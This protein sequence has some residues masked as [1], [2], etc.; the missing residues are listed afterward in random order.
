MKYYRL[1]IGIIAILL[2]ANMFALRQPPRGEPAGNGGQREEST[3]R[4]IIHIKG[5]RMFPIKVGDSTVTSL[6]GKVVAYHNGSVI[7]CDS[8]VRFSDRRVECFG[9][10]IINKDST[11]VYGDR[12][13]YDGDRNLAR[14]YSPLIKMI[15]G[16]AVLYTY[17]FIFNTLDN[18]GEY[19]G[20]GIV[21]RGDTRME[22]DKG[23]Y[24][25]DTKDFVCVD[26]A[27]LEDL[28]YQIMSDSLGYNMDTEVASFHT[29]TY[30]WNDKGEILSANKGWY[31]TAA[32]HYHFV[33]DAYIMTAEQ[34][35]WADDINYWSNVEDAILRNN[36]QIREEEQ[37][38]L[39]F[40]DYGLYFGESG[41]A[42]LTENPSL[43][44]FFEESDTLYMRSDTI[45]L[46]VIDSTSIYHPNY[47][48]DKAAQASAAAVGEELIGG[49]QESVARGGQEGMPGPAKG[50]DSSPEAA[51]PSPEAESS[52]ASPAEDTGLSAEQADGEETVP[53]DESVTDS[54]QEPEQL[55]A[56]ESGGEVA[57]E[58]APP[59]KE[60]LRAQQKAEKEKIK[61][62]KKKEKEARR[63][64]REEERLAKKKEKEA[65]RLAKVGQ[66]ADDVISLE[67]A[68]TA[69]IG[70]DTDASGGSEAGS[71][72]AD[73]A[74]DVETGEP[75]SE[76]D[77]GT[78][79]EGGAVVAD[80]DFAPEQE[81]EDESKD[82]V[83][84]GY[85]NVKIW[86]SDFQAVCDSLI[87]FSIDTTI[88]MHIEPLLWSGENQISSEVAVIYIVNEQLSRAVFSGGK[89]IM[90]SRIDDY[91][92]NQVSGKVI[93]AFFRDNELYRTDAIGNGQTYYFLQNDDTG[94][95]QGFLV[96]ES[97]DITFHI[98]EQTVNTI[99][100]RGNPDV[101]IYPMDKI[102]AGQERILPD[103]EWRGHLR[104][105]KEDVFNRNIRPSQRER[106][107]GMAMP[108]F[109]LTGKILNRK[110]ELIKSGTWRDRD[111]D[112]SQAARDFIRQVEASMGITN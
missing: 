79:E 17:N 106:Y 35:V 81:P 87:A 101:I 69:E 8:A 20:G 42:V 89:P 13:D 10:V 80:G 90:A 21:L 105:E 60:E 6:V 36:I 94:E 77:A 71:E 9:N 82:R 45:F 104:P 46:Y 107:T 67:D 64:A 52:S 58:P 54:G 33:S 43:V 50:A 44:S 37:K 26:D 59:T 75:V 56:E 84:V 99:V 83:V 53:G 98:A 40:G 70:D 32:D 88:H 111:E 78:Q 108:L 110:A 15:D 16:D 65:R 63:K 48:G 103:F 31:Y 18:I 96:A 102:P 112:I 68:A 29:K 85:H 91:H 61:E 28:T 72:S 23:Y 76:G 2:C 41:N 92:F 49:P 11:Y 7:T 47:V 93:E 66:S 51:E 97:A 12:A 57:A 74:S 27:E 4:A 3:D 22:S 62:E 34:E 5:Q 38:V 39:A 95:L 1:I 55:A 14:V 100:Y 30:I 109:P 73:A 25:A 86:R 19:Y 24:Y